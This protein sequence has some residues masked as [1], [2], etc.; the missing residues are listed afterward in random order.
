MENQETKIIEI[1]GVKLEVDLRTA[2]VID[3]YKVGDNVKILVKE[4][5]DNFKSHIGTIIGFDDFKENPTIVVAYLKTEYSRASI[6]FAYIN[7]KNKSF[8]LCPLNNWDLPVTKSQVIDRFN[9]EIESKLSEFRELRN[10]K[11]LFLELFGKY[12]D[13]VEENL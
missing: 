13:K 1:N 5:S 12:F 10:R 2:K 7:Q 11:K 4:Y 9:S 8:E 3:N 6:E